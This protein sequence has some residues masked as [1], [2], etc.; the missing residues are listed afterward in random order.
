MAWN[1]CTSSSKRCPHREPQMV[2][3]QNTVRSLLEALEAL[4]RH[5]EAHIWRAQFENRGWENLSPE[6]VGALLGNLQNALPAARSSA[7]FEKAQPLD[8]PCPQLVAY[9]D[10]MPLPG[11]AMPAP[12]SMLPEWASALRHLEPFV[13]S[14]AGSPSRSLDVLSTTAKLVAATTPEDVLAA[15]RALFV[16]QLGYESDEVNET[17][18]LRSQQSLTQV[19][20]IGRHGDVVVVVVVSN[21]VGPHS[22]V[23]TP[24]F[25]LH[26]HALVVSLCSSA[27]RLRILCGAS[28][29]SKE[30]QQ[31]DYLTLSGPRLGRKPGDNLVVYS[32]RIELMRPRGSDTTHL[33]EQRIATAITISPP[34]LSR[35]W[36]SDP[37][38]IDTAVRGPWRRLPRAETCSYLQLDCEENRRLPWG[39]EATLRGRFPMP[40][41]R[42]AG[43]VTLEQWSIADR[44]SLNAD[45]WQLIARKQSRAVLIDLSLALCAGGLAQGAP[46]QDLVL[47]CELPMPD[48][49]GEFIIDGVPFALR[50]MLENSTL[51]SQDDEDD[52]LDTGEDLTDV[53]GGQEPPSETGTPDPFSED[54]WGWH[55]EETASRFGELYER[56]VEQKLRALA[57]NLWSIAELPATPGDLR[58]RINRFRAGGLYMRLT[59]FRVLRK[60]LVSISDH[61]AAPSPT[62]CEDRPKPPAWACLETSA[63]LEPNTWLPI[64][65]ACPHPAGPLAIPVRAEEGWRLAVCEAS[66]TDVQSARQGS[67][68]EWWIADDSRWLANGVT[69]RRAL[70]SLVCASELEAVRIFGTELRIIISQRHK[71]CAST[72]AQWSHRVIDIPNPLGNLDD[73]ITPQLLVKPGTTV[74][75]GQPWAQVPE[76]LWPQGPALERHVLEA[77]W[78]RVAGADEPHANSYLVFLGPADVG[79]VESATL[80]AIPG[81]VGGV[82]GWRMALRLRIPG[83][84]LTGILPDGRRAVVEYAA[85]ADLPFDRHGAVMAVVVEDPELAPV[86]E[87]AIDLEGTHFD[88]KT[89]DLMDPDCRVSVL[90]CEEEMSRP[91][92][93]PDSELRYRWLN[94]DGTPSD[95]RAPV[96]TAVRRNWLTAAEPSVSDACAEAERRFREGYPPFILGLQRVLQAS[97]L[98]PFRAGPIQ[99]H[100]PQHRRQRIA[101]HLDPTVRRPAPPRSR[102][103]GDT[104][105]EWRCSCGATVGRRRAAGLCDRCGSRILE[106]PRDISATPIRVLPLPVPV[107]HP[108]RVQAAAALLGLTS[109]ELR[110]ILQSFPQA[111]VFEL[112]ETA[113]SSPLA[114]CERRIL[115]SADVDTREELGKGFAMLRGLVDDAGSSREH[116]PVLEALWLRAVPIFPEIHR[117]IGCPPGSDSSLSPLLLARYRRLRLAIHQFAYLWPEHSEGLRMAAWHSLQTAT[118]AIF[119]GLDESG[120]TEGTLHELFSFTWPTAYPSS[121]THCVPGQYRGGSVRDAETIT[122]SAHPFGRAA[123]LNN[124][125]PGRV[126]HA[127]KDMLLTGDRTLELKAPQRSI[128]V[129]SE[130]SW[131]ERWAYHRLVSSHLTQLAAVAD[132]ATYLDIPD[133]IWVAWRWP[134]HANRRLLGRLILRTMWRRLSSANASP[135]ALHKILIVS[136]TLELPANESSAGQVLE[137]RLQL[138]FPDADVGTTMLRYCFGRVLSA[139]TLCKPDAQAPL[140]ALWNARALGDRV[141]PAANSPLW[142]LLPAF[143]ALCDPVRWLATSQQAP[144]KSEVVRAYLRLEVEPVPD[145]W[146]DIEPAANTETAR[147]DPSPLTPAIIAPSTTSSVPPPVSAPVSV[148]ASA[149][150]YTGSVVDWIHSAMRPETK[151]LS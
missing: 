55:P 99:W 38:D 130:L 41:A 138:C 94:G 147:V 80:T 133:E 143:G 5:E 86:P 32:R 81:A 115:E 7:S 68:A 146:W 65:S 79:L 6:D 107:L 91:A 121:L 53:T 34:E 61:R 25:R 102:R 9:R 30:D 20:R 3:L 96:L 114:L 16:E 136:K 85:D 117:L 82:A 11:R 131:R 40:I 70:P 58:S 101:Y 74:R 28:S 140:G 87:A 149:R 76:E 144:P 90:L 77:A 122:H 50:L 63:C 13:L 4:N 71:V 124:D 72:P 2:S 127:T 83:R 37:L 145:E 62:I 116:L 10:D 43:H 134:S 148:K 56:A 141:L 98:S 60:H 110:E 18:R 126:L 69:G 89:G 120:D 36:R 78:R 23:Y 139:W 15:A 142:R 49:F 64:A 59:A 21:Y 109:S 119:G 52:T 111:Y 57:A 44:S 66:A 112:C 108:W 48:E 137:G 35:A 100:C 103:G 135:L 1:S 95:A 46:T 128:D 118:D 92:A 97:S 47:R 113:S 75:A 106:R 88:G 8:E 29:S 132:A 51:S 12:T 33:L 31:R 22:T 17:G 125:A 150:I 24:V 39:L 54:R 42:G 73:T 105:L 67:P 26:P 45:R 93:P 129:A 104:F 123:L 84:R 19:Q 27:R 151:E 14:I